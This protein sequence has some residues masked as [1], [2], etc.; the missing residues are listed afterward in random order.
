MSRAMRIFAASSVCLLFLTQPI[1]GGVTL[2]EGVSNV[3]FQ[4]RDQKIYVSYD[5]AGKG[6]YAVS[7]NLLRDGGEAGGEAP[8]TVSGDVGREVTPGKG[9]EIVWDALKDVEALEGNDFV[10]EVKAVRPGE[11]GSKW[12]W[13][14]GAG[15][16]GAAGVVALSGG[17]GDDGNTG[18]II[19][20]VPDPEE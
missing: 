3:R 16:A 2:V 12:V 1:Q 5:L 14:L 7:L 13:V 8:R 17:G 11:G 4:V 6:I 20:E 15:A 10:F 19:I 9:K 18:K